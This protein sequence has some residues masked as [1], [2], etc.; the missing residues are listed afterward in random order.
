LSAAISQTVCAYTERNLIE[1]ILRMDA[2]EKLLDA[3]R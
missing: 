1:K 3:D 2:F